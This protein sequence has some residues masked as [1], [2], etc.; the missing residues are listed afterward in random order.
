MFGTLIKKE[1]QAILLSPKFT[2]T[3]S[4]CALLMLLSTYIGIK[5]YQTSVKE[6][7]TAQQLVSQELRTASGWTGLNNKSYRKPDP[8]Q[9]FVTG[10]TNDLGRW[11][12]VSE[13]QTIKLRHSSY[14]EDP[15]YAIFRFLDFTFIVQIV[16]SLFALLFTYDAINGE[17]ESGTLKLVLSNAIPRVHYTAAKFIGSWLGLVIPL[18]IP[19]ALSILLVILYGVPFTSVHWLAFT[20]FLGSS[21]LYF[22]F[23]IALGLLT[24]AFTRHSNV[25]FLLSFV[26]WIC[27]VLI[28]PRVGVL[29]AGNLIHVPGG[30]E[31]EGIRDAFSKDRWE[32]YKDDTEQ[33]YQQQQ[34]IRSGMTEEEKQ[35]YDDDHMWSSMV[36]GDSMRKAVEKDINA[37]AVKLNEDLRNKKAEQ[38]RLALVLSR[39]SPASAYQLAAMNLAGT[40][41]A[42]KSR[43]EDALNS[44]RTIFTQYLDKKQKETG[45]VAGIRITLDTEKGFKVDMPREQ[46]VMNLS[47][48][49]GFTHPDRAASLPAVDFGILVFF[50]I[51]T[52]S[53]AFIAF[54]RYDVR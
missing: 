38:E 4:V 53:G 48:L 31:I 27:F 43:Y 9:V 17:R 47:D 16:L 39:F 6:F 21:L 49:P 54:L 22:T 33:Y 37:Y 28:I 34:A 11:S 52:F 32:R 26:L 25:S 35:K 7:T 13:F 41:L 14:S 12:D 46:G 24:S 5:G 20:L 8:L 36:V 23:F 19:V 10:V 44:Y 29:T 18:T 3:F 40:D 2:V 51:I 1:L 42:A 15:I 30:A 50:C 45:Q